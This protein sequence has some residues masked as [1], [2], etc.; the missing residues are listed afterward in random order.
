MLPCRLSRNVFSRSE[1][2]FKVLP[3]NSLVDDEVAGVNDDRARRANPTNLD[4]S[5]EWG[6]GRPA[7]QSPHQSAPATDPPREQRGFPSSNPTFG[8]VP[9]DSYPPQAT[10]RAGSAV[11]QGTARAVQQRTVGTQASRE[12]LSFRVE[13]YDSM[14]NRLDPLPVELRGGPG[15]RIVG[16]LNENDQVEVRGTWR[17]GSL[18]AETI[19][20]LSTGA[21]VQ[22]RSAWEEWSE[23]GPGTK[24]FAKGLRVALILLS[25]VMITIIA[26]IVIFLTGVFGTVLHSNSPSTVR[27]PAVAGQELIPAIEKLHDAGIDKTSTTN[28]ASGTVKIGHVIRT[29]PPAGTEVQ[30]DSRVTIVESWPDFP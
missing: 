22:A 21:V 27:I 9:R 28:E 25:F 23:S 10:Q 5:E 7:D 3:N 18:R 11:V 8:S 4:Q 20:N 13:H 17:S 16:Q 12:I 2:S 26:A 1:G 24:K 6:D 29:E 14:G 19:I 15:E 30:K